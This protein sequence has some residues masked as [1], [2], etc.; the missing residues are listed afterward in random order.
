M[1]IWKKSIGIGG[2]AVS[3]VVGV[4]L[5]QASQVSG[6]R[7]K[8]HVRFL[9]SDL[10]EGRGV[11][12]RG[13]Q[14]TEEY[15]AAQLAAF[16]V[17]PA[18]ENG[19]YFQKVPMIGV[20]TQP[21]SEVTVAKGGQTVPLKWQDEFVGSTHR[22]QANVKFD[23]EAIFVGHGIVN[24]QEKWDDYKGVS[25]KDKIVVV[26]TNEPQP[27]NPEVFKGRTLTYAGRWVYKFEEAA[28]QGALGCMIIHT[29]PTAGYGWEVVRNSWS[30]EDPQMK[31]EPN[32]N[33]L[34]FAGWVTQAAGE[35]LLSLSGHSVDSL[36][37]AADSRDFK[38]IPLGITVRGNL[39]AKLRQIESRNILGMVQGSDPR[40]RS[41]YVMYSAH[42]DHLGVALPVNGDSIYNGAI[43]NATGVGVV[44][45]T[46]R[47]FASLRQAPRR[48]M[49]FAFWTAEE[50]GLRGAEYYS[51]HP[52]APAEKTAV[53]INFDALFPSARTRDIV[54][55]GAERTSLWP[56]AQQAAKQF[57][58]EIAPDPR[59]EQGSYY[60][61]DHFMM[62]RIGVPAF[63]IGL[64]TKIVGK[65]EEF[66]SS[67]FAE[68]NTKRYHQPSD[69]FN[70]NWDFASLEYAARYGF[71]IGLNAANL[72]AMPRWNI[73]D[74]FAISQR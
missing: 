58:L 72:E 46:A 32:S 37:K 18:G 40:L 69:E 23:A 1:R 66:A 16:G 25:V 5:A 35:R 26:F 29:T 54:L 42:W 17:K 49:L 60:R 47:V 57:D 52:L 13:G 7:I 65:S 59:P 22:Q 33:A 2:I 74:E 14:L 31:L 38:P 12:T 34:A 3:G 67:E 41:E 62:A 53:N 56:M 71:T 48:S 8:A 28:R 43:D 24:E 45:E 10:L 61:S 15:I 9:S 11:G 19:T 21:T 27:D 73:G 30:K 36:L 4:L 68:Y 39:T 55:T 50:S 63:K 51:H 20:Q 70:E 44:L 64:G 6:S